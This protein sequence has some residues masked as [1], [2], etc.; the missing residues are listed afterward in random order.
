[1]INY[2]MDLKHQYLCIKF[3]LSVQQPNMT[4]LPSLNLRMDLI[5]S[6]DQFHAKFSLFSMLVYALSKSCKFILFNMLAH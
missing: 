1:M 5:G 4:F 2:D 6:V 3:V